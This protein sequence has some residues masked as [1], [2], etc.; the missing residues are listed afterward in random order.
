MFSYS[1]VFLDEDFVEWGKQWVTID[2]D[3]EL[4]YIQKFFRMLLSDDRTMFYYSFCHKDIY[5]ENCQWHCIK[6]QKCLDWKEWH[7]GECDK[8][9]YIIYIIQ[10]HTTIFVPIYQL[11]RSILGTYGVSLSCSRCGGRSQI[12]RFC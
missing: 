8:C 5:E 2:E 1:N 3:K 4:D 6:C 9:M 7:C 10:K 11:C 12:S